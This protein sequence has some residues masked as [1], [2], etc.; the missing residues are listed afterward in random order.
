VRR[1]RAGILVAFAV[2]LALP[3]VAWAVGE[4]TQKPGTAGCVSDDGTAGT[5]ADGTALDGVTGVA[6][7]PDGQ[8]VYAA[9]YS[10]S[11]V[12]TLSRGAGGTLVQSGCVTLVAITGCQTG[13][14]LDSPFGVTVS[15][16][17]KQVYATVFNSNAVAV[18]DR[19]PGTGALTQMPGVSA[20]ASDDGSSGA[21]YD[22]NALQSPYGLALSPDGNQLYVATSAS[23]AV[24]ILT[25]NATTGVL[26]QAAG[27]PGC[28]SAGGTSGCTSGV[29]MSQARGV[30]VSPD[31]RNVYVAA[32]GSAAV[33]IL[34]RNAATGA[35]SQ[36][37]GTQG[38]IS[39]SVGTCQAG[40][41]LSGAQGVAVSPDGATVY[42]AS[43]FSNAIAIF[44][45]DQSTGALSQKPG[46]A[47][48]VSEDGTGGACQDGVGLTRAWGIAV[49]PDGATVYVASPD[50]NAVAIFDRAATGAL[51]QKPGSAGCV[52]DDGTGGACQDGRALANPFGVAVS[53][54]G[55]NVYAGAYGGVAI[56][57]R[58]R[59]PIV[60]VPPE[61]PPTT[62]DVVAPEVSAFKLSHKRFR[63]ASGRTAVAA[64]KKAPRGTAFRFTLSEAADVRIAI[65]RASSGR[66]VGKS[67][68]K[69]TR[70]LRK[71]AKCT[72][73]AAARTLTRRG[74]PAGRNSIAFTGRIGSKALA[75]ATYRA[76]ITA[77][78]AAGNRSAARTAT[79]AIVG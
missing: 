48:C 34:D 77:T 15:P 55:A 72:R 45:R 18:F 9:A 79:F 35:L 78:D 40:T 27:T 16:D 67:C 52:S 43:D 23:S 29:A 25:R 49:S 44:D 14:A 31:G 68:R 61:R 73:Y 38:C 75:R 70:R 28:I 42:V 64:A 37:P 20:C 22:G 63:V 21:C 74:L 60:S 19:A 7:S 62:A 11:G 51:S 54:D 6:V 56:F 65:Q 8:N 1:V 41:A 66:K 53:P 69:P 17:G 36:K 39:A 3:A 12:V 76:T 32:R 71:R 46:P 4:L 10:A 5:C 2:V 26:T 24:A 13:V 33:D 47:G 57:D 50:S 59:P 58:A 30:A